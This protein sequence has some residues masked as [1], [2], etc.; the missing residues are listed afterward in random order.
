MS[1]CD[2]DRRT[3]LHVAASEGDVE[4][5]QYL[6]KNGAGVHVRD[7]NNDTPL[8]NAIEFGHEKVIDALVE[9]GAHI[10]VCK[11]SSI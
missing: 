1:V 6:M 2:Y 10:Q 9:C 3:P 8:M 5:V 7:R 11:T 4:M